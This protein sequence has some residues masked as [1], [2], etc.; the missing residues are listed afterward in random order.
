MAEAPRWS[1]PDVFGLMT[2]LARLQRLH[3]F[4]VPPAVQVLLRSIDES[5]LAFLAHPGSIVGAEDLALRLTNGRVSLAEGRAELIDQ[6]EPAV[7][8]YVDQAFRSHFQSKEDLQD[9]LV[10]EDDPASLFQLVLFAFAS[11][12]SPDRDDPADPA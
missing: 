8:V 5:R 11:A 6:R 1:A 3:D 12:Q 4:F 9:L 2:P 10:R 7:L